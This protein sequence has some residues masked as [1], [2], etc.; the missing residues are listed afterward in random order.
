MPIEY[1]TP[2][3]QLLDHLPLDKLERVLPLGVPT[4]LPAG[5]LQPDWRVQE[6]F[7]LFPL[8]GLQCLVIRLEARPT[9]QLGTFAG[10][11][12]RPPGGNLGL[13]SADLLAVQ[14]QQSGSA[15]CLPGNAL[16]QICWPS[17]VLPRQTTC[18]FSP[19]I[20]RLRRS[21]DGLLFHFL[22]MPQATWSLMTLDR[23][24]ADSI[25]V[26]QRE[27]SQLLGV[28]RPGVSET[29]CQLQMAALL[30]HQDAHQGF[31]PQ[32]GLAELACTHHSPAYSPPSRT[33]PAPP[34][35][36][37]PAG[38]AELAKRAQERLD[39]NHALRHG[40]VKASAQ[41]GWL[42]LSGEVRWHYQRQDANH[43][44]RGLP[45]LVGIEDNITVRPRPPSACPKSHL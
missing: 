12:P 1:A 21:A 41:D 30:R 6:T 42:T 35:R 27:L 3:N 24:P 40:R 44:V 9:L 43:C 19:H 22:Q 36:L 23:S 29:V 17:T 15:W 4:A 45:G 34:S 20:A 32:V 18:R 10:E 33:H 11:R 28:S 8:E 31:S 39:W 16:N 25:P 26:T 14:I 5:K 2:P 13:A 38:D 7:L 37:C